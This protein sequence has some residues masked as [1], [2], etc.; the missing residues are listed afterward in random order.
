MKPDGIYGFVCE[1]RRRKGR[2]FAYRPMREEL[3]FARTE[4]ASALLF[5]L[6]FGRC[7]CQLSHP[8]WRKRQDPIHSS[9][10]RPASEYQY[11]RYVLI[12]F[13]LPF[14]PST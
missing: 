13:T 7:V 9:L 6:N 2:G 5:G 8:V 3:R 14:E 4:T 10:I 1:L 12:Y 11:L